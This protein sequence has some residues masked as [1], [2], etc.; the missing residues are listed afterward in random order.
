MASHAVWRPLAGA[1]A[2]SARL[3]AS[4]ST[5]TPAIAHF[6]RSRAGVQA[7]E[8]AAVTRRLCSAGA[9]QARTAV[10]GGSFAGSRVFAAL[11]QPRT[12]SFAA[13][14]LAALRQN[15]ARSARAL[16]TAAIDSTSSGS[17]SSTFPDPPEV[18]LTSPLVSRYLFVIGGL[19]FAIVVV[20]GMTRL[21]ESG[22]SIT[23][24]NVI[25]GVKLPMSQA[26][27]EEEFEKYKLTPEWKINNQHIT[28]Q[29]FKTIYMWE[30]S[31][32]ILGR[33]I[34]VAFLAPIPYFVY[35][36]KLGRGALFALFGIASLIG[37]Q[38]AMGWYMVKSGLDEQSVQDLGGVPRVSQYR[39][40]AHLGLAFLVYSACVRFGIGAARDWKLAKK[41]QGLGGWKTVEETIRGL[42][43]KV[44]GR[45]RVLVTALTA[46]VFTTA[47]SGAF[48]AG[49]DAGLIYNEWPLMGGKLHPP[50]YELNKDFY[51]RKADKSDRWRNL[52][53]NPTT[54][55]FDHR[56]LAYTTF[57][58]VVSLFLYARRPHIRSQLPPLTYRLIKGSLH[59]SVLQLTLG[60]TTLLYLVPTHLAATHQ[61]GSLVLLS[62]VL[63]AGASLRRPSKV[64]REALRIAQLRQ[65]AAQIKV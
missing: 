4:K 49:L 60:I 51:C 44:A 17:S 20:G 11:Q 46:L 18:P 27:W 55:Q 38:G 22:L 24:W 65:K 62:L 34:G 28:L 52:F 59:M 13:S 12:T 9:G 10:A 23:E 37:A 35:A 53:E 32:R 25:K 15:V 57:F 19:V 64:A 6:A 39:L 40:A 58:S 21:T 36:R 54:V 2:S 56:M 31:H 16:T 14:P 3:A 30:W 63:A 47:L 61:A 8:T 1:A 5:P 7:W 29:D 48:V 33:I 50:S 45:T 41:M 26:E 43:G 42:E